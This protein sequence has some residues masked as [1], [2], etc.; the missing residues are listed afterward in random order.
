MQD[1]YLKESKHFSEE[2]KKERKKENTLMMS[3]RLQ[4]LWCRLTIVARYCYEQSARHVRAYRSLTIAILV[5]FLW[6]WR[7]SLTSGSF[8]VLNT[9]SE[10]ENYFFGQWFTC[11][12]SLNCGSQSLSRASWWSARTP[13]KRWLCCWPARSFGHGEWRS[14]CE[15]GKDSE[16]SDGSSEKKTNVFLIYITGSVSHSGP[17]L[18]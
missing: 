10:Y 4:T 15:M 14:W 5:A 1:V 6:I 17:L 7:P 12:R 8:S 18:H 3:W 11:L 16:E 9:L 2:R 13:P